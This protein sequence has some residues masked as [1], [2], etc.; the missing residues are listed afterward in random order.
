MQL[1]N[2]FHNTSATIFPKVDPFGREYLTKAQIRKVRSKLCGIKG[3]RCGDVAG[4]RPHIVT[5]DPN[6]E[7]YYL[8]E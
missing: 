5:D 4:C 1:T 3:C 6:K 2:D 8:H 7:R